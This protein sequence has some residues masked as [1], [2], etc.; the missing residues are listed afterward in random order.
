MGI[1]VFDSQT[2]NVDTT[3]WFTLFNK[4][5]AVS[6]LSN[7]INSIPSG[8]IV[9]IGVCDDAKNNLS[10]SLINAIKT[11]GSTQI[12]ELA[13]QGSW[14]LIGKKGSAPG[15]AIEQIRAPHNGPVAID[16]L[17]IK[18]V[19]AGNFV[20]SLIGPATVWNNLIVNQ[21]IPSGTETKFKLFGVKQDNSI[22]TLGYLPV[23]DTVAGLSFVDAKKYPHLKIMS[24]L[25]LGTGN[26][27]PSINSLGV[28][29][30]GL[31][32]L[33]TNY[34]AVILSADTFN[35]GKTGSVN[36]YVYNAGDSRA[37]SVK[38]IVEVMM[39]DSTRQQ[40]YETVIDTINSESRRQ[41]SI[42]YTPPNGTR[43]RELII[44]VDPDNRINEL[45]KD[46]NTF[47][48]PFNVK[49]DTLPALL[50]ITFDNQDILNGDFV[51]SNPDIKVELNDP[52]IKAISDTS[53]VV[54]LLNDKPIFYNDPAI[55]YVFNGAN[56]KMVVHY[57]PK[58]NEGPYTLTVF[59]KDAYG[60][61]FDSTGTKKSFA[62]S[63]DAR[64]LYVYNYP[65]PIS[66]DTYFTFKLT[67]LPD[68]L[69]I[70]IYTVAGRLIRQIT[71]ITSELNYDFNRIYWDGKDQ[72]GD[73][74]ATEFISIRLL[75][76]KV[77][78][79]KILLRKWPLFVKI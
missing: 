28:N 41:I 31:P 34:Q 60:V 42:N 64:I 76:L 49:S 55:S 65:D 40:I 29:Y 57:K 3:T 15:T 52:T 25:T 24:E 12:A 56:P 11:L 58:L 8:K 54:I 1:V 30:V 72:D 71:K 36:F 21:N 62:V 38:V 7:L 18:R 78:K 45:Y 66:K 75:Y 68:E 2:L 20:T 61:L 50:K 6:Q 74:P 23:I 70:N 9:A 48:E 35:V 37:D 13:F 46:N 77:V 79:A 51:S 16:T 10:D 47:I 67:Q 5:D 63:K 26:T 33:G 69:K 19:I 14:A 53:A 44:R 73:I 32:E 4:P 22:D 59:G 17:Y 27:P 39:S 43:T